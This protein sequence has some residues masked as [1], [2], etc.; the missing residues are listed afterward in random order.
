[1][2]DWSAGT[3]N[4]ETFSWKKVSP[5]NQI[6]LSKRILTTAPSYKERHYRNSR[7]PFSVHESDTNPAPPPTPVD[8]LLDQIQDDDHDTLSS[9]DEWGVVS[10]DISR[11]NIDGYNIETNNISNEFSPRSLIANESV[12]NQTRN[13]HINENYSEDDVFE[14][15]STLRYSSETSDDRNITAS[16]SGEYFNIDHSF[17]VNT[18]IVKN[19]ER[20]PTTETVLN[21]LKIRPE[22]SYKLEK[23]IISN[24]NHQLL[25]SYKLLQSLE[26]DPIHPK[27]FQQNGSINMKDYKKFENRII[28]TKQKESFHKQTKNC[29]D[30]ADISFGT[31]PHGPIMITGVESEEVEGIN[32]AYIDI[33]EELGI[34]ILSNKTIFKM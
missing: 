8:Y 24:G 9:L 13:I 10:S 33:L 20:S 11:N 34:Y 32:E 3:Q 28:P 31:D 22:T 19:S 4:L 18:V 17:D 26:K 21:N 23:H 1:M 7:L 5:S 16:V 15:A 30:G 29:I 6:L 25:S 14:S 12:D 27:H 2:I